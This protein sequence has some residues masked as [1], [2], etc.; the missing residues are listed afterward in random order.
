MGREKLGSETTRNAKGNIFACMGGG[1][2][3]SVCIYVS[4]ACMFHVPTSTMR[5]CM[6]PYLQYLTF[7]HTI[8]QRRTMA[9]LLLLYMTIEACTYER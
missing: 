5:L 6:S 4:Y 1:V 8:Q 9:S 7:A 3:V 2:C